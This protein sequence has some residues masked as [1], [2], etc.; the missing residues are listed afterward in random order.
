MEKFDVRKKALDVVYDP[1]GRFYT[2]RWN[3]RQE[4]MAELNLPKQ[5]FIRDTTLR[6]GEETP[7]VVFTLEQKLEIAKMLVEI[8]ISEIDCG[9]ASLSEQHLEFLK[10]VKSARLGIKTMA[11]TRLDVPNPEA[12]IDLVIDAGA[13]VVVASRKLPDLEEVARQ[14]EARGRRGLAV[15]S[16]IAK[17][18]DSKNLVDRVMA[19][20]GRIDILLNNA[21][22]NPYF[23]PLTK[24]EEWAWDV[25]MN[26]N[27][28]GPFF[29]SQL[30]V[31][32][33]KRQGGGNIINVASIGGFEPHA[34]SVYSVSKAAVI[35]LTKAMAKEWGQY[36]IRVNAVAPGLTKTRFTEVIWKDPTKAEERV[37]NTALGRIGEPEDIA[38]VV[39]FLASDAS[40][41]MTGTIVIVDGGELVGPAP[42]PE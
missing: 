40:S 41:H 24:V 38:R 20:F 33:M 34:N 15:A 25:M 36:G 1:Q 32:I 14:I 42:W 10:A 9:F 6:E 18:E 8:G 22:V 37:K 23:G 26:V 16:H 31:P 29:L 30:I 12:G 13:D 17:I 3:L 4:V 7:G 39:L 2:S 27:V 35:M 19:E 28:K 5:V 21:G 11:L